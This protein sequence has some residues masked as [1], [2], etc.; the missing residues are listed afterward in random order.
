MNVWS[1]LLAVVSFSISLFAVFIFRRYAFRATNLA[2]FVIDIV[3]IIFIT[4]S[5]Y[6]FFDV[7]NGRHMSPKPTITTDPA[8]E[9]EIRLDAVR[10]RIAKDWNLLRIWNANNGDEVYCQ[11]TNTTDHPI[12]VVLDGQPRTIQIGQGPVNLPGKLEV[13]I[14]NG[15]EKRFVAVKST[16]GFLGRT[17][18]VAIPTSE[19]SYE[20]L[21]TRTER[22]SVEQTLS[23]PSE[24]QNSESKIAESNLP[25]PMS[26][27]T[28]I[29]RF[30]G[31]QY[32]LLT[33]TDLRKM[34]AE[35]LRYAIN[36]MY[37]RH[38]AWFNN[39]EVRANFIGASWYRPK[40]GL[41]FDEIEKEFSSTELN[42]L[43]ILSTRRQQ[44]VKPNQDGRTS[45]APDER[46]S[47]AHPPTKKRRE[48]LS[49]DSDFDD[50]DRY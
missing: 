3:V 15:Y 35:D 42:N 31:T 24:L 33:D 12:W 34:T 48:M 38:G 49:S 29:G 32:N 21:V 13:K 17:L 1:L 22:M 23:P 44:S 14:A 43:H 6:T 28:R 4:T 27:L 5:I 46:P 30:P 50:L 2:A 45:T 40:K 37:A 19:G 9:E 11:F 16:D 10:N 7:G 26:P 8:I 20:R 41:S 25:N 47:Y 36:E 39:A 18:R